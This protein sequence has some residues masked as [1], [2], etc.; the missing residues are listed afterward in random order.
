VNGKVENGALKINKIASIQ[1]ETQTK[2]DNRQ[3]EKMH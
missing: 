1:M 3:E 2:P